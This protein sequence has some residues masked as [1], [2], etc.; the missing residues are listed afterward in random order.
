MSLTDEELDRKIKETL[1][2]ELEEIPVPPFDEQWEKFKAYFELRQKKKR[3]LTRR[4][5]AASVVAVVVMTSSLTIFKP[6]Q[7][8]AFG[9]KIVQIFSQIVGKT[10][11]NVTLTIS[12]DASNMKAPTVNNL[13]GTTEGET[14]LEEAQKA[15][16]FKIAVPKYLPP[17]TTRQKIVLTKIGANITK[18]WMEYLSQGHLIIFTQQK[19]EGTVSQGYMYDTD[20]TVTKEIAINGHPATILISKNAITSLT[21]YD[22]GLLFELR[23]QLSE[24]EC[25]KIAESII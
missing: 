2:K 15:V 12:N 1:T 10:T 4:L 21:W 14:T 9:E 13:G 7:A 8:F 18:V 20:D 6:V 11:K 3:Q 22:R 25:I 17:G 24:E 19:V 16:N 5:I 23:G